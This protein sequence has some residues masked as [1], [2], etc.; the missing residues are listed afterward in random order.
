MSVTE[1]NTPKPNEL[2]EQ[3]LDSISSMKNLIGENAGEN[4]SL[5]SYQIMAQA[6]G[7]AMLNA[8]NQQQQIY[9]L[10]NAA[11]TATVKSV[12]E[13]K[14]E[15]AI[16]II[17]EVVKNNNVLETFNGLKKF[18]DDLTESYNDI[19]DKSGLKKDESK[20]NKNVKEKSSTTAP[21]TTRI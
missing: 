7:L 11:T 18:M 13:S 15:E 21:K 4:I 14:P 5:I 16:K 1:E 20:T 9:I 17:N 2:N 12:L 19:K 3:I 8:V 6:A 10:Q